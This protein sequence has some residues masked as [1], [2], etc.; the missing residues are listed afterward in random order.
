MPCKNKTTT[1]KSSSSKSQSRADEDMIDFGTDTR[2][3]GD[4]NLAEGSQKD[5]AVP[6]A[7]PATSTPD[8]GISPPSAMLA[9]LAAG[10]DPG[11]PMMS[12][13][14]YDMEHAEDMLNEDFEAEFYEEDMEPQHATP[15]KT[16][17]LGHLTRLYLKAEQEQQHAY[18]K[19]GLYISSEEAVAIHMV[20]VHWLKSRKFAPIPFRS[21]SYKHDTKLLVLALEKL[22]EAYSVKGRLNQS[23]HKEPALIEQAYNNPHKCPSRIK[24]LLLTQRAFKESGIEFF[25]TYD[26][27][28]PCY[29]IKPVE[30]ITHAYLDQFLFFEDKHGLFPA[31]IKLADTEPPP[32]LVY[33]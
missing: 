7:P 21:L 11:I 17:N 19:D 3:K 32:L 26:K 6:P 1:R 24:H 23:Q 5:Q 25:D 10:G 27:L 2:P 29:D 12:S 30:K 8:L 33:K 22:K 31:W 18:L 28:I 14:D 13:E 9:A 15:N 20:T 4:A 16:K